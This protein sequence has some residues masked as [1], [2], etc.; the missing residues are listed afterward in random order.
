MNEAAT[1]SRLAMQT[2]T[3]ETTTTTVPRSTRYG[4]GNQ[5]ID[6]VRKEKAMLLGVRL[7]GDPR[8]IAWFM[9]S[10]RMPGE[11]TTS[12]YY[13]AVQVDE[14]DAGFPGGALETASSHAAAFT[15]PFN[16]SEP[17]HE[18]MPTP[19]TA[20]GK[21]LQELRASIV[22]KGERLLSWDDVDRE[23]EARR[24]ERNR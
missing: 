3:D 22:A 9:P 20:L 19:R 17:Q 7:A 15:S 6:P 12:G 23:L 1:T 24:G 14:G 8:F 21:R 2:W 5:T 13:L 18:A 11:Q 4:R 16:V 10:E